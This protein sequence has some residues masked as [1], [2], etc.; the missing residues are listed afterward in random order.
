MPGLELAVSIL[1]RALSAGTPLL[2]GTLGEIYTERAGIINLGI[3]GMMSVGAVS[4]FWM[5]A[6]TGSPWMGLLAALL[7]GA[8]LA[9]LHA[10]STVWLRSNQIV[11]G[12]AL[13][14]LGLGFS[15]LFGKT[16]IG[17]TL[18]SRFQSIKLPLLSEIPLLGGSLF[19]QDPVFYLSLLIW[20]LVF[21]HYR[22]TRQGLRLKAIGDNPLAAETM[23]VPVNCYKL[24]AVVFG[25]AMAGLAGGYLSLVYIPAWIEGMTGGRGF[26]VI[27]LTISSAWNPARA[28]PMAYLFSAVYVLQ[29]SFL[30]NYLSPHFLLML[31]YL[32]TLAILTGSGKSGRFSAP[33]TLGMPYYRNSK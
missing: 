27:A 31:P 5:A 19:S 25:G 6:R 3:E 14:M 18:T 1:N 22:H 12:L 13:T 10:I 20:L 9:L 8:L 28:A 24:L 26:I 23:C 2:L 4:G 16:L 17:T 15:G 7:A 29:Y 32:A 21:L 30:Q 33:V 11:S